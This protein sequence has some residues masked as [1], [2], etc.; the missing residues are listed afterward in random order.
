MVPKQSALQQ[1]I[2]KFR[3]KAKEFREVFGDEGRARTLE[4]AARKRSASWNRGLNI[5]I[6]NCGCG[7]RLHPIEPNLHRAGT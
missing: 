1:C 2:V 3:A 4:W 6:G 5:P 7:S